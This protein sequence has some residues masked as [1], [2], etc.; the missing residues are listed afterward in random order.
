MLV[1]TLE[2]DDQAWRLA[3]L[4]RIW[5][6]TAVARAGELVEA[7]E[8]PGFVA[9]SARERVGLL[10]YAERGDEL[11]VVTLHAERPGRGVGRRLM[12]AVRSHAEIRGLD[13]IWLVT[14]NDNVRALGFYQRWGMDL[15]ALHRDG[16]ARSRAVKPAIPERSSS[17]IPIRHELELELRMTGT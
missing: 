7:G 17:G 15:V 5:G 12:D 4:R 11:E 16:A 9:I 1:R 10:T 14:T 2:V 8:L 6:S 3:A 13:R